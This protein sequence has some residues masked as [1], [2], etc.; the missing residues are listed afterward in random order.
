MGFWRPKRREAELD[1]EVRSHLEMAARERVERGAPAKEAERAAR[2]E[3][4]NV[5]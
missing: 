1:E 2:Q 4:G 3:C 5:R